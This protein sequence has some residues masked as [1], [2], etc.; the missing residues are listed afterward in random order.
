[1]AEITMKI[2]KLRKKAV[3]G[4]NIAPF[5]FM[6]LA[7]FLSN[8]EYC[9]KEA[10]REARSVEAR[11]AAR[12]G[13]KDA[14]K[15][16]LMHEEYISRF[17]VL[18][19]NLFNALLCFVKTVYSLRTKKD[20]E[21]LE[22]L[23]TSVEEQGVRIFGLPY[24]RRNGFD[25]FLDWSCDYELS[26]QERLSAAVTLDGITRLLQFLDAKGR[27]KERRLLERALSSFLDLIQ[28]GI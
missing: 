24:D 28:E 22:E 20:E 25:D 18:F 4:L 26:R 1:M 12:P 14:L 9:K 10:E 5:L 8:V 7:S 3:K 21:N 16:A 11:I 13:D 23:E 15:S 17:I 2:I 27:V 19:D 6:E